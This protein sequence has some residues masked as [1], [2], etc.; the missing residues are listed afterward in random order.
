MTRGYRA[1]YIDYCRSEI[2]C[3]PIGIHWIVMAARRMWELTV[4]YWPSRL[5][6]LIERKVKE[7]IEWQYPPL[8]PNSNKN[9]MSIIKA[10][11]NGTIES[12]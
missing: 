3:F 9:L 4:F 2:I 12:N 10:V 8:K 7:R 6:M 11:E 5:E 1:V